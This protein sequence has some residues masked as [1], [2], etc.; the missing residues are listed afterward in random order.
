MNA[1]I[2]KIILFSQNGEMR[3]VPLDAGLNIITGDS[4]TGK[5]ALIEIV[6]YCL[7]SS[8]ST[9]PVG[10][11]TNFTEL[12]C[13]IIKVSNKYLIIARPHWKSSNRSRAYFSLEV[14]D[15]FLS[16]FSFEYFNNKSLQLL[17]DVQL[18]VEQHLGLAVSDTRENSYEDRRSAGKATMRSFI[19]LLFQHQNL[20]ANKHS[21]FYRFDD[22]QKKKKTIEQLPI[23]LGWVDGEYYSLMQRLADK[24]QLLDKEIRRKKS[25]V[26][27]DSELIEKLQAPIKLYCTSIGYILDDNLT[28]K[29]LKRMAENLPAIPKYVE[30]DSDIKIQLSMLKNKKKRYEAELSETKSL[31]EQVSSNNTEAYNYAKSLNKINLVNNFEEYND[32]IKCPLCHYNVTEIEGTIK[33]IKKSREDLIT[34]LQNIGRY[35]HD[36]S[37]HINQL[38][39]KIDLCKKNIRVVSA[40]IT[41]LEKATLSAIEEQSLREKLMLLRGRIEVTLEHILDKPTLAQS[42]VD[43]NELRN[44]ISQL[45]DRLKGYDLEAKYKDAD[46]F[47]S[48]RMTEISK[49][50][51]FEEELQPGVMRFNLKNFEFYYNYEKENIRLSEM[52]SGANWLACHLSLFLSLLHLSCKEPKSCIPSFLFI[53]QPSQ[54]YFPKATKVISIDT[55][56]QKDSDDESKY[57]EN[58][59]QVKNIF[60]VIKKEISVIEK[61]CGFLP[62]IVIMEH[63][64]EIEFN[65]YVKKRWSN[66]GDKL[67]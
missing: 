54:V 24:K 27:S 65:Q 3:E 33:T 15:D 63:A 6:D 45:E 49:Q 62:Q 58:I 39:E 42:P 59:K 56:I 61:D 8:R 29:Q 32:E 1:Y 50:L 31:I 43:I 46:S 26:L 23:L 66:N 18:E 14:N 51:D 38:I 25:I 11:I 52:G 67:I 47:I 55:E 10:K 21:L 53:D 5:S 19:S 48:R 41:N 35:E 22:D 20:I 57:D 13:I 64:D 40:E 16:S 37:E 28:L 17:K 36:S 12:F 4:K 9:I 2:K 7:F 34:E 44:E 30:E 60:N